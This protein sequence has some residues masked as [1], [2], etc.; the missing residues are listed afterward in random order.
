MPFLA[1]LCVLGSQGQVPPVEVYRFKEELTLE[2][3]RK[4][5]LKLLEDL[6]LPSIKPEELRGR[7]R[8]FVNVARY[9]EFTD[10]RY[11]YLIGVETT[12]PTVKFFQVRRLPVESSSKPVSRLVSESE[13][14]AHLLTLSVKFGLPRDCTVKGFRLARPVDAAEDPRVPRDYAAFVADRNGQVLATIQCDEVTGQILSFTR[15]N[16]QIK[17]S[18]R[19]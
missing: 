17:A 12:V 8:S 18:E 10:S 13:A 6:D 2:E 9:W 3:A 15:L 16:P 5:V 14:K 4:P 19:A 1:A 11:G 7:L